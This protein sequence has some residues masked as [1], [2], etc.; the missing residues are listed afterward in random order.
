MTTSTVET[1]STL[2][3]AIDELASADSLEEVQRRVHAAARRLTVPTA[4]ELVMRDGRNCCCV[5]E[6]PIVPLL[7]GRS[8]ALEDCVSAGR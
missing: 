3:E 1:L 4:A 8:F 7:K 5:E 2:A 6:D